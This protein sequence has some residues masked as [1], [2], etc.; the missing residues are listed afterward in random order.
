MIRMR[1]EG[2]RA[3]ETPKSVT[4]LCRWFE[5]RK[6]TVYYKPTNA[7][8]KIDPTFEM[9]IK[10]LIEENPSLGYRAAAWLLG[11][12][13]NTVQRM[14]QLKGWHV[15]KRSIRARPRIQA[16]PQLL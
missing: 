15:H 14:F 5:V 8:P 4:K 3:D 12:D 7:T 1:H 16:L 6:R 2:L 10:A 11:F 9:P 13:K